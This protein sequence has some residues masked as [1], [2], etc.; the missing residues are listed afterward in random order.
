MLDVTVGWALTQQEHN[1]MRC[2]SNKTLATTS[3]IGIEH[4]DMG[5]ESIR[6]PK[7]PLST[8][9]NSWKP[10]SYLART[11][12]AGEVKLEVRKGRTKKAKKSIEARPFDSSYAPSPF[13]DPQ[14][15][16][17]RVKAA[18]AITQ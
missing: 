10:A 9:L 2:M 17:C 1:Y 12:T 18:K 8:S 13:L 16:E 7:G 5:G 3:D 4:H 14:I 6:R 11:S 15:I